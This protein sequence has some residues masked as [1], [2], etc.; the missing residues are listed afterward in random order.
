MDQNLQVAIMEDRM[1]TL[2]DDILAELR[3]KANQTIT[4]KGLRILPFSV[5]WGWSDGQLPTRIF[6]ILVECQEYLAI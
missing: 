6:E 2:C 1:R 3:K 5:T 4:A